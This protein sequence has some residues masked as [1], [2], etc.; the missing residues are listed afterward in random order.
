[1]PLFPAMVAA[2]WVDGGE[3][4]LLGAAA[5]LGYLIGILAGRAAGQR[6]GVPRTLDAGMALVVVSL[7]ACAWNGGFW[8]FM[9]WRTLA[10][11]GGGLLM[12][13]AGPATQ[14]S[15]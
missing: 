3:A 14:A 2:G 12:A 1:M 13:L 11:V 10:G 5:L 6:L 9:P 8:W 7:A 15:V 4:G